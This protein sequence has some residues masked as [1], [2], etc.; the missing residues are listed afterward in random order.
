MISKQ[1][2]LY[3]LLAATFFI[4]L[5]FNIAQMITPVYILA[6]GGTEFFS[7]LQS[8][9]F[10]LTAVALRFFFGPL[11]DAKGNR[12]TL[13]IGGLAFMTAPLLFLFNQSLW[14]VLLV[15]MY[16]AIGLA[17]YFSSASAVVSALA[18]SGKLGAYIGY[19]RLVTMLTLLVGPSA[20]L[21]VLNDFGFTWYHGLGIA[22]GFLAM[23]F[24]HFV[25]EPPQA[26]NPFDSAAK[27]QT[28]MLGLLREKKLMPIFESVFLVSVCY[29]LVQTFTA[30]YVEQAVQD[31]N[32]GLFFTFFGIGSIISNLI[33]GTLSDRKGRAA[34]V[35]PWIMVMG[36][37]LAIL[38]FLPLRPWILYL[39]SFLAG[40][41]YAGSIA[42]LITW[43][44]DMV[45]AGRRT[46]AL[47]LE[48]NTIDI[49][50]GLGS[51]L[52][53]VL[54]PLIGMP[55]SYGLGGLLLIIFAAWKITA[56]VMEKRKTLTAV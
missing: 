56:L 8:T 36:A 52:F 9:L 35:F 19:Y 54:I 29:G 10:Y 1:R 12:L 18:P 27:P 7:G 31:I 24:L 46:T 23:V 4:F 45:P 2:S 32:P 44:V 33:A 41:G 26:E 5:N 55:W 34:V 49:G 53:G 40:F 51:F 20:A 16:Q 3:F 17:A 42:V 50:I 22:V 11:A 15:R 14:Y 30:I 37:G 47:A 39:G 6:I 43:M 21:K 25:Q 28:G 48:D 13:F 38:Y